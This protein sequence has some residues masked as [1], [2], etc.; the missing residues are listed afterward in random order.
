VTDNGQVEIFFNEEWPRT[1]DYCL[2]TDDGTAPC[3]NPKCEWCG[4]EYEPPLT[5]TEACA[6][7]ML[8]C[9]NKFPYDYPNTADGRERKARH[10]VYD[11]RTTADQIMRGKYRYLVEIYKLGT[12]EG[13]P[14]ASLIRF[15]VRLTE[16]EVEDI[17]ARFRA[18]FRNS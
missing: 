8:Y 11:T 5:Y 17:K 9:S 18:A 2:W 13:Q 7:A 14:P 1:T 3:G 15:D 4:P 12:E 10:L 16:E 6:V